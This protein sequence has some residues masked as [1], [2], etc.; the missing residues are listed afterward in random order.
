MADSLA[1]ILIVGFAASS[2]GVLIYQ[3]VKNQYQPSFFSRLVWFAQTIVSLITVVLS[4]GS[5]SAILLAA[6]FVVGNIPV[7]CLS[8]FKGSREF[9]GIEKIST[10]MLIFTVAAWLLLD[11]ALIGLV[12]SLLTHFIGGLPTI[13]RVI[14]NPKKERAVHWYFLLAAALISLLAVDSYTLKAALLPL[15][16][17]VF[18]IVVVT[19]SLRRTVHSRPRYS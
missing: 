10:V 15:Y 6:V 18:D 16:F 1:Y 19:L 17:T 4:D 11:S 2:Y 3:L 12:G 5:P 7:A 14:K 13:R 9:N 8:Y